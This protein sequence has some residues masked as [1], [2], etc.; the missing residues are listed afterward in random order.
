MPKALIVSPRVITIASRRPGR[1]NRNAIP[2]LK[3][4]FTMFLFVFQGRPDSVRFVLIRVAVLLVLSNDLARR[5]PRR[6]R[7]RGSDS[8]GSPSRHT[9]N[10]LVVSLLCQFKVFG[11]QAF[12]RALSVNP[13]SPIQ[14]VG[15]EVAIDAV[16]FSL[17]FL[18]AHFN[19][20]IGT[21]GRLW[22]A[23]W[24][25]NWYN[26]VVRIEEGKCAKSLWDNGAPA[27]T[28]TRDPLLRS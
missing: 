8:L 17:P 1:I 25:N 4:R 28:R 3:Q 2:E 21:P 6:D 13:R 15:A 23:Y 27:A 19:S 10:S 12:P 24:Y 16:R 11:S 5:W 18:R 14:F 26:A 9:H 22:A 7:R 20:I